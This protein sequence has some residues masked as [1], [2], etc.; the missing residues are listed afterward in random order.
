M[1]GK[2]ALLDFNK[3]APSQCEG[4]VCRASFE[5]PLHLIKQE[6]PHEIPMTDPFACKGCGACVLACPMRAFTVVHM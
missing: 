1:P 3:C 6:A 2:M 5:C 4:E